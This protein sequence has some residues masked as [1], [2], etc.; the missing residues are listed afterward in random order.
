[1]GKT[2]TDANEV[3]ILKRV[4]QN[5]AIGTPFLPGAMAFL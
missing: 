1:M 4:M 3:D 2:A 5:Q